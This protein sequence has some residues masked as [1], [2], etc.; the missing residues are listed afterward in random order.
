MPIYKST[1]AFANAVCKDKYQSSPQVTCYLITH[2]YNG[3]SVQKEA[4]KSYRNLNRVV[5]CVD[6]ERFATRRF[7]MWVE[8]P[9]AAENQVLLQRQLLATVKRLRANLP[10]WNLVEA[11]KTLDREAWRILNLALVKA[12][13]ILWH[14]VNTK[15][16]DEAVRLLNHGGHIGHGEECGEPCEK[17]IA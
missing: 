9:T 2:N 4:P 3:T 7:G 12:R 10:V 14:E 8:N 1:K 16:L 17:A 11:P 6:N 5:F 15:I 13:L